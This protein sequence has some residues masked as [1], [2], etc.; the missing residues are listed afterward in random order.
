MTSDKNADELNWDNGDG[1]AGEEDG[2][3]GKADNGFS[4][5]GKSVMM[6]GESNLLMKFK[7]CSGNLLWWKV[8]ESNLLKPFYEVIF[9][10]FLSRSR[11]STL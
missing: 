9:K 7:K 10:C 2:G 8:S 5:L 1:N 3:R 4:G 6:E 11:I